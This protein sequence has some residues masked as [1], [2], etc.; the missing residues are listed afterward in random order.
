MEILKTV[1]FS[2]CITGLVGTAFEV[3]V[4]EGSL[5]KQFDIL[6]GAVTV[7]VAVSPFMA[8]GFTLSCDRYDF[9]SDISFSRNRIEEKAE[10]TVLNKSEEKLEEYFLD[11]LNK[12]GIKATKVNVKLNINKDN[13]VEI[14][15]VEI[16]LMQIN[17]REEAEKVISE[18]ASNAEIIIGNT[19]Q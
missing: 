10:S 3:L 2:V 19:S 9:D 18:D 17:E 14:E 8:E 7:L 6:M 16:E 12:N 1:I 13:E 11:K 5:K 15:S 4:P